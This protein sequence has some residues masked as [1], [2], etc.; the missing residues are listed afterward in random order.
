MDEEDYAFAEKIIKRLNSGQSW[1]GQFPFK[2]RSGEIF[3]AIV[4]RSPLYE[5]GDLV[6]V[7]TVS[8]DS[9]VFN[10]LNSENLQTNKDRAN[11]QPRLRRANSRKIQWQPQPQ[12]AL[13]ISN[14]ASK[15][16]QP[17]RVDGASNTC[18]I[19]KDKEVT[20]LDNGDVKLEKPPKIPVAKFLS[21][22][23]IGGNGNHG[24]E[25]EERIQQCCLNNTSVSNV[26]TIQPNSPRDLKATTSCD[27]TVNT[28]AENPNERNSPCAYKSEESNSN[29]CKIT[30]G[31]SS[32]EAF[33]REC[34]ECSE[35]VRAGDNLTRV[36]FHC[37]MGE[38]EP[39][40]H[41][42]KALDI[43]NAAKLPPY[44]Q[45][46]PS[47]GG[48][49]GS[50]HGSSSSK[51]DNELNLVVDCEIH[52]EDLHLQEEIGEG[53]FAIVYHGTWNGSD[54]AVKVYFGNC[55]SEGTLL[56]YK[57]EIDI[58]RRL[59]HPNV[60]LFMGAV[61]AEDK[62]KL[63]I[64]TEFLPRGSLFRMLHKNNQSL[65]IRRRLRMA[66]DVAK[67]MN[68]LHRRNPP[69]VHRDLKSSNL[70]VDKNWTVKV[71]DFGL[72]RLKGATFLTAKSGRGTI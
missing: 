32:I 40:L 63:A 36:G 51:G 55:Y 20:A 38:L 5:E 66:L 23:H 43:E 14:L 7:I 68:Y 39:D 58:M 12:I 65:D 15:V 9:A 72:S 71:G 17:R 62:E 57:K 10:N 4:T 47:S 30:S 48:S 1:S 31:G 25:K 69:I 37:D 45:R 70:L 33:S 52:W 19:S 11:G 22:L 3:T 18:T 44:H 8:S 34:N 60:L 49:T 29:G 50:G 2:K 35:F 67:G 21:K 42:S 41:N 53:S 54:V 26:M 46:F 27:H 16:L 56:D 13:S 61:Y 59:R 6:G 24:K 64:V 28:E